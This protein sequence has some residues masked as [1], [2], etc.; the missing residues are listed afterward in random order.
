MK[1]YF[2]LFLLTLPPMMSSADISGTCGAN[3]NNLTWTYVEA[4]KTL[5]I[6]G[7]GDM[8]EYNYSIGHS[9]SPWR[10]YIITEVNKTAT[11][12]N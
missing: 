8:V 6:S 4:T 10:P 2:I 9:N 11:Q 12:V 3:G 7:T 5:T 1:R